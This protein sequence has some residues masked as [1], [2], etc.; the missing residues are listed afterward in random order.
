MVTSL[1][2]K[3]QVVV[4]AALRQADRLR[5]GDRFDIERLNEGEYLLRRSPKNTATGDV[6]LLLS[7]P[8]K[9]WFKKL[10]RESTAAL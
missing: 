3:G 1:S 8:S 6:D 9:G 5:A 7:C 2:S 10:P 4:P